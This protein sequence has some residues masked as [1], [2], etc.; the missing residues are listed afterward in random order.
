MIKT[1]ITFSISTGRDTGKF[2]GIDYIL[3]EIRI[4]F[5]IER[6]LFCVKPSEIAPSSDP[7]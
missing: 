2:C 7:G 1:G 4:V 3:Y 6:N 5:H